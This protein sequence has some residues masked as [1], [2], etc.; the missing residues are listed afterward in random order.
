MSSASF[1]VAPTALQEALIGQADPAAASAA[2]PLPGLG[3]TD[4]LAEEIG[5]HD[6]ALVERLVALG[7]RPPTAPAFEALPLVEVAWANGDVDTEERWRA[8]AASTSFGLELGR[9]CHAQLE[10]WLSR[11]PDPALFEAWLD[12]ARLLRLDPQFGRHAERIVEGA[13]EVAASA[14]G[15]FGIGAVSREERVLIDRIAAALGVELDE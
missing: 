11:R 13:I 3:L 9:P 7:V 2:P 8:L 14:G 4:L 12:Y 15:W 6:R 1:R 5:V 10:L